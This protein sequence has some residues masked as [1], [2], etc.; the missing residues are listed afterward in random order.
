MK[1][2]LFPDSSNRTTDDSDAVQFAP[3]I[4]EPHLS[5]V[6]TSDVDNAGD[7]CC[8]STRSKKSD[9]SFISKYWPDPNFDAA[10]LNLVETGYYGLEGVSSWKVVGRPISLGVG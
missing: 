1:R 7:E 5:L 2:A 6:Y 4:N 9:A 8:A 3:N 10:Q